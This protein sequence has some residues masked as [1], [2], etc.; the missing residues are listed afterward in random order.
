MSHRGRGVVNE[1]HNMCQEFS[2]IFRTFFTIMIKIC[3]YPGP[4]F[5]KDIINIAECFNKSFK[6]LNFP[7]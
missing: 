2:D 5:I 6:G 1:S 4:I 3:L 7:F